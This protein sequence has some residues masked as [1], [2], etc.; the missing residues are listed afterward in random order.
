MQT[1]RK[2][3]TSSGEIPTLTVRKRHEHVKLR[4]KLT[5]ARA[6]RSSPRP[7]NMIVRRA[8][9]RAAPAQRAGAH[10]RAPAA[11]TRQA[12]P[13]RTPTRSVATASQQTPQYTNNAVESDKILNRAYLLM[14]DGINEASRRLFEFYLS[15]EAKNNDR[16]DPLY[17]KVL[18]SRGITLARSGKLRLAT[19]S[20]EALYPLFMESARDASYSEVGLEIAHLLRR[21]GAPA[22]A[23]DVL[24]RTMELVSTNLGTN[25][26]LMSN[27]LQLYAALET[28]ELPRAIQISRKALEIKEAHLGNSEP[29]KLVEN[30]YFLVRSSLKLGETDAARELL[31]TTK[32]RLQSIDTRTAKPIRDAASTLNIEFD[33]TF[34]FYQVRN[35]LAEM[36]RVLPLR[37]GELEKAQ[38]SFE[39]SLEQK[40][41]LFGEFSREIHA[42]L[43]NLHKIACARGLPHEQSQ[44]Y[45]LKSKYISDKFADSYDFL[46]PEPRDLL[47]LP[48]RDFISYIYPAV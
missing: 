42:D 48:P 13:V 1:G 28:A 19:E 31:D 6:A 46:P 44:S 39:S 15:T 2:L 18:Q 7:H 23:K 38:R 8:P 34:S 21:T 47:F 41:R 9:C 37:Q 25:N 3:R 16:N 36:C 33:G 26:L 35:I 27:V 24:R 45:F 4:G 22:K 17:M 32:K 12:R 5:L 40:T 20:A 29:W 43:F 11:M 10:A 14:N 30:Y